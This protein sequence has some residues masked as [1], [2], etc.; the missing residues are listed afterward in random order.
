[1]KYICIVVCTYDML[2]RYVLAPA[3][4]YIEILDIG[5]IFMCC[6]AMAGADSYLF[7]F[8]KLGSIWATAVLLPTVL[9]CLLK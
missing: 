1:M 3:L 5:N 4:L 7:I 2:A 8:P 9:C 6:Y